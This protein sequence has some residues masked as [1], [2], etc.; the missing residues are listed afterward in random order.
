[1]KSSFFRGLMS[2]LLL[3]LFLMIPVD[4]ALSQTV[5]PNLH[6]RAQSAVLMDATSGQILYEENL[7][8]NTKRGT[9][10][11]KADSPKTK[12]PKRILNVQGYLGTKSSR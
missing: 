7:Q 4:K 5:Q 1:M 12:D 6:I 3:S 9:L 2:A 8:I 11:K 10:R